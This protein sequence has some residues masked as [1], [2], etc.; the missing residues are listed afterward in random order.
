[1]EGGALD[2]GDIL[3]YYRAMY[4]F[5]QTELAERAGINEKY[6]GRLERNESVPS[7]EKIEMLCKAFD[8]RIVDLFSEPK[9]P[10]RDK[11]ETIIGVD[12]SDNTVEYYCN[13]CGTLFV[14]NE[15]DVFCPNCGCE[16]NETTD[17]IERTKR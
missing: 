17:Y 15:I 12:N 11:V 16:F 2:I 5:T 6:Y 13:C 14:T 4:G 8:I 7:L 1:M 10:L 3:K 9:E